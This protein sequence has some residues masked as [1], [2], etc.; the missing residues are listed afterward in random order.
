MSGICGIAYSHPQRSVDRDLLGQMLNTMT[1]R[2]P[3]IQASYFASQVG[4]G[5]RGLGIHDS[6]E[7]DRPIS[8]EEETV[9]V[10]CSGQIYNARE[11]KKELVAGGHRFRTGLDAEVIIHLYKQYGVQCIKSLRGMYGFALWDSRNRRLMLGRDRLGIQQLAYA[12]TDD[13]LLFGSEIKAILLGGHVDRQIDHHALKDLFTIGFVSA[14]NTLFRNIRRL[15]PGHYLLYQDGGISIHQYWDIGFRELKENTLQQSEEE[16]ADALK[17]K[18]YESVRIHCRGGEE[19]GASLSGGIDS[20]AIV[21]LMNQLMNGSVQTFSLGYEYAP[22]DEVTGVKTLQDFPG[23]RLLNQRV[24]CKRDDFM[25]F[26]KAVWHCED[27]FTTGLEIP[28]MLLS[29]LASQHV[30]VMLTGDGSDEIFG[31]YPWFRVD[32]ALRPMMRLPLKL[33]QL[34]AHIP[35]IKRRWSRA[36]RRL[37]AS[38]EMNRT[39]YKK[40]IDSVHEDYDVNLFADDRRSSIPFE[41]ETQGNLPPGYER[42]H[43]FHQLLYWELKIHLPDYTLRR[44]DASSMA[45]SLEARAP[46]LDHELVEL[47]LQ[48]PL[49][50]GLRGGKDKNLFRLAMREVV[51]LEII[52]RAKR[53][54]LAPYDQWIQEPP[55]FAMELLSERQ[56]R[57]KGYFSPKIVSSLLRQHQRGDANHG[58][59][60]LGVIGIQLWH[61]LFVKGCRP[62]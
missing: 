51:P 37:K 32:H 16:W 36:C 58:R 12:L 44:L 1:H 10:V 38:A 41:E 11:L 40:I 27:P 5:V 45:Y 52:T 31:A 2:G 43:A 21:S 35:S 29:R 59:T 62:S 9:T 28:R 15:L 7:H 4:L 55:E 3:G 53:G 56:I 57:E 33:R 49:K 18:L 26:P 8:N 24:M 17:T 14:P 13:G 48:I 50:F 46:F 34:V 22:Y 47:C 25:L 6:N 19:I 39:C 23:F 54:L 60:L 61:D 20:S 42:W 30:K